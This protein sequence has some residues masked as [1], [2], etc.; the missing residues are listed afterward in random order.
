MV[1]RKKHLSMMI[2]ILLLPAFS[3]ANGLNLNG[4]GSRALSMGGAFVAVAN[5]FSAIY[6]NPAGA[7]LFDRPL[8]GFQVF[9]LIPTETYRY[10]PYIDAKSNPAHVFGGLVSYYQPV[11]SRVVVGFGISTPSGMGGEWNIDDFAPY[12]GGIIYKW[13][14]KIGFVSFS[15]LVAVKI[16]DMV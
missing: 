6:W 11:N 4:L 1:L 12:S 13:A 16:S 8:A 9:D 5:D 14:S 2:C 3:E 7:A 10:A 15:P